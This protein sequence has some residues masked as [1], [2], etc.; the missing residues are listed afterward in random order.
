MTEI[1]DEHR[2]QEL[3]KQFDYIKKAEKLLMTWATENNVKLF[4][5]EF[6]VPFVLTDKSVSVW[7]FFDTEAIVATYDANGIIQK[8]KDQYLL[9]LNELDYPEE[10]MK[11]V[12]FHVDSDEQVKK[13]Y[14]GN[15][16]YRLR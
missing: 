11:E 10:Y 12:S 4:R 7:L 6:V 13:Y 15:Y 3:P 1:N 14:Q 5:V 2:W 8:V 16:F 9:F